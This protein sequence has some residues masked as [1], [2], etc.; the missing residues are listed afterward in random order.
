MEDLKGLAKTEKLT[1]LFFTVQL[2][3]LAG[4]PLLGGFLAKAVVVY[5]LVDA[6]L[7][8]IAL[9]TLLNSALSVAYYAW[10]VKH[11]YFDEANEQNKLHQVN[12]A[13]LIAQAILV[14]GTLYFGIFASTIF[15]L[16][17]F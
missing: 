14:A 6:N 5:A 10:I 9:I 1:A 3:S 4:I 17:L 7:I 13:T 2:F 8:A 15:S 12:K 11:I 16:K